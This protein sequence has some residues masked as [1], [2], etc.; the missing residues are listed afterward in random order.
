[1]G[2]WGDMSRVGILRIITKWGG[3]GG[4]GESGCERDGEMEFGF[5]FGFA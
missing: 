1:M 5:G 4:G 2:I 3:R